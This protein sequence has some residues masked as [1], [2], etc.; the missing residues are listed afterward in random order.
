MGKAPPKD[1]KKRKPRRRPPFMTS[2]HI[3][4]VGETLRAEARFGRSVP[5]REVTIEDVLAAESADN[6]DQSKD[7]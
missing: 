2:R 7:S 5:E 3:R 4:E 6:G 1:G